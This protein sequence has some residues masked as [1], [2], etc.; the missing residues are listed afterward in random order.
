MAANEVDGCAVMKYCASRKIL[1]VNAVGGE[2]RHSL[3]KLPE[4][5]LQFFREKGSGCRYAAMKY[6]CAE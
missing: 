6:R 5:Q 2:G 1:I 4:G 3:S